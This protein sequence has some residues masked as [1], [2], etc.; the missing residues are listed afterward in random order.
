ME[1]E[2]NP[3]N[4]LEDRHTA[5]R[6]MVWSVDVRPIEKLILLYAIQYS[7]PEGTPPEHALPEGV[8]P[9]AVARLAELADFIQAPVPETKAA[10][11]ALQSRGLLSV[12]NFPSRHGMTLTPDFEA[13]AA[14]FMVREG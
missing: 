5:M 7:D 3:F 9:F 2:M 8:F 10:L 14:S 13:I 1:G 6:R 4:N 12:G 11:A